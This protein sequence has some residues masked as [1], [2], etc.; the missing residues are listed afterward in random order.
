M[1]I[2]TTSLLV[3]TALL[4]L[5]VSEARAQTFVVAKVPFAFTLR[6]QQFPAG[7]YEIREAGTSGGLL[8]I[9]GEHQREDELHASP[10]L[11]SARTRPATSRRWSSTTTKTATGCR[12][13]GNR[14]TEGMTL[15]SA[16]RGSETSRA[17]T[18]TD[19][20]GELTYVV[21][22]SLK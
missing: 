12:R 13:S 22:A 18:G 9:Q 8:S 16:G 21:A 7:T 5:C 19:G 3:T 2:I 6:G 15:P 4:G 20:S 17:D 11:P 1:R 14:A 10:S